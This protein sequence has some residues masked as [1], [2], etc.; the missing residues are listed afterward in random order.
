M[1]LRAVYRSYGGENTKKRPAYYSKLM[2]LLSFVRTASAV[3]DI[4]IVFV[5]D[6]PIPS[7]RLDV[8]HRFGRAIQISERPHGMR[9]SYR[10]ALALA[11]LEDWADDDLVSFHE[12]DYL[13]TA[14]A[15]PALAEAASRLTQASYFSLYG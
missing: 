5:N 2:A 11:D 6:G 15:F 8:M 9:A 10:F 7:D 13:Y 1:T 4:D 12:D 3:P 14:D